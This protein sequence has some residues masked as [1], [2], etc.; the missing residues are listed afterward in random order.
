MQVSRGG[1]MHVR[2]W[3]SAHEEEG[4]LVTRERVDARK[5]GEKGTHVRRKRRGHIYGGGGHKE[6]KKKCT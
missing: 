6:G 4:M 2:R 5:D 1:G 3:R